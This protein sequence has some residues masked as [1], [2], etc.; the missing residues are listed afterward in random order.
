MDE[1]I[2]IGFYPPHSALSTDAGPSSSTAAA[3][4]NS[5]HTSSGTIPT[6]SV[7]TSTLTLADPLV[8]DVSS[9]SLLSSG[10]CMD[11]SDLATSLFGPL[12]AEA[13]TF[14]LPQP[15][16][17]RTLQE[18]CSSELVSLPSTALR[19]SDG[20]VM[21]LN[22][23]ERKELSD[24]LRSG[25]SSKSNLCRGCLQAEG[26]RQ[27]H[28]TVRDID[29]ATHTLHIDIAGPCTTSDDGFAYFLVGALRLPGFPLLIDV[30]LLS[31][32]GSAEVCDALER[33]VAFFESLQSEG[34]TVTDSS[35]V[36][37]LHSDRAGEFTAPYFERFLTNHKSI[38]HTFTSGYDPQMWIGAGKTEL[39]N[40]TDTNTIPRL[41]PEQ[42]DEIKRMARTKGQKYIELPAKAV[43]TIKPSKFK[44]RIVA[45]GNKT[46]ETFSPTSTTDLDTG[47]MRYLV[48]WA[49]SL[50]NFCLASLDVTAA[51]LN[52]PLP[53]GRV[54]VLRPPTILYKLNLLPPGHVWLVHKAIYVLREAPS[55]RSEERTEA[56]TNLTFTS[57]GE[58]YCVLLSQIHR[59]LCLIVSQRS[60]QNHTPVTFS[61]GQVFSGYFTQEVENVGS[62]V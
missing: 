8:R 53:T 14:N 52:A 11:S 61:C 13:M 62:R 21:P 27:V 45:C 54:V 24:H 37:R 33:M 58:P 26:P 40:L 30:R 55:L 36:K 15:D 7:A 25:H 18:W 39:D 10:A 9:T 17:E 46:D 12:P 35:R 22:Q 28:R 49:A 34:F 48:S 23:R 32:R 38:Y 6:G 59:S 3:L 31:T 1:L 2:D 44:L 57:E 43:F 60:L 29:K 47:M 42:R 16:D 50:P 4:P 19:A 56:L 5:I 20:T 51:F 41:S